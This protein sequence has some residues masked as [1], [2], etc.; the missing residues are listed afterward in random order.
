MI[1][2]SFLLVALAM[3]AVV[4]LVL[5]WPLLKRGRAAEGASRQ[6]LA[7]AVYRDQL[8]ELERD[9]AAG[10]LGEAELA[11]SGNELQR[12][13]LQEAA[14]EDAPPATATTPRPA[15]RS[16][17]GVALAVPLVAGLMYWALGNP[18]AQ[19]Q[20][21]AGANVT[22]DQ[23]NQMVAGLA[24]KLEK[25]TKVEKVRALTDA[26]TYVLARQQGYS[27]EKELRQARSVGG[28]EHPLDLVVLA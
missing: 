23:V 3:T 16:A 13:L 10:V 24:A 26:A 2:L 8:S 11:A 9:R 25:Q 27:V 7:A 22:P 15:V 5:L 28:V 1:S 20:T 19:S 12:R 6:A 4:L 17:I 14:T 21:L 18:D